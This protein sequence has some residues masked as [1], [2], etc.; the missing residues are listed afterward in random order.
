MDFSPDK[1]R[2]RLEGRE[3]WLVPAGERTRYAATA[4]I[5]RYREEPE[6]LF[7]RRTEMPEDPW[8]G[9]MA[10]PG[11][12]QDVD[13]TDL[14]A[15]AIRETREEVGI[16]LSATAELLGRLDD[17][18]ATARA[19]RLDLVI[20]PHVFSLREPVTLRPSQDEVDEA[21]W[22]PLRPMVRGQTATTQHWEHAGQQLDLPGY[23]VGPHVV[24]GL[25]YRQLQLLFGLIR[26]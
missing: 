9:Q 16:D 19:R 7:I 1:L 5:L 11:G 22:T 18:Q 13:D 26:D 24:W 15:T 20:V 17:V 3:P 12:R 4:A 2:E 8:S 23:Q 14:V 21:L 10:F 6:I 25:T